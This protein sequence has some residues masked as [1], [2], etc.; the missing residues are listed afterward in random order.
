MIHA[1]AALGAVACFLLAGWLTWVMLRQPA[2]QWRLRWIDGDDPDRRR[3]LPGAHKV[4]TPV[5]YR[6][7]NWRWR[8]VYV[9]QTVSF[10]HRMYSEGKEIM[11]HKF[12]RTIAVACHHGRP[13][14]GSEAMSATMPKV[15]IPGSKFAP[16]LI[17]I[18]ALY[19]L[20]AF[21]ANNIDGQ[22]FAMKDWFSWWLDTVI[23][24]GLRT[25]NTWW[26]RARS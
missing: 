10:P 4:N 12:H 15:K 21:W 25:L 17:A 5:V 11:A 3:Q 20:Q 6:H 7:L 9:G 2:R 18:F 24:P 26:T 8:C 23:V 19:G 1:L 14:I 16:L 13:R 22:A